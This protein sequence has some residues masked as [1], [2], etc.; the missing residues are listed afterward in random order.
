MAHQGLNDKDV[1]VIVA[2]I[3][4]FLSNDLNFV[5]PHI[6]KSY[7]DRPLRIGFVSNHFRDHS[8]GRIMIEAMNLMKV[9][10][11]PY[12]LAKNR[13][14]FVYSIAK[15]YVEEF[16]SEEDTKI[17]DP[18]DYIEAQIEKAFTSRFVRFP[19]N[20]HYIRNQIA[21]DELDVLIFGDIGMDFISYLLSFSRLSKLQVKACSFRNQL[22]INRFHTLIG[23]FLGAS[24]YNWTK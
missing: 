15:K 22:I 16:S 2:Q 17:N 14:V 9:M 13:E 8:I 12:G 24:N 20:P 3:F 19:M 7:A 23:G 21:K 11:S 1:Q 5:A 6:S 18:L 10:D 4:R